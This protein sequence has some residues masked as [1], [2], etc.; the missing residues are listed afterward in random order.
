MLCWDTVFWDGPFPYSFCCWAA[1][2]RVRLAD[3][4]CGLSVVYAFVRVAGVCALLRALAGARSHGQCFPGHHHVSPG[5]GCRVGLVTRELAM[6]DSPDPSKTPE[7]CLCTMEWRGVHDFTW[8]YKTACPL[9]MSRHPRAWE[10]HL[11]YQALVGG[12]GYAGDPGG[13]NIIIDDG[14]VR[15]VFFRKDERT[16]LTRLLG[17][18]EEAR[19]SF[20]LGWTATLNWWG[21][22][23]MCVFYFYLLLLFLPSRDCVR[24]AWMTGVYVYA[25]DRPTLDVC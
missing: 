10:R 9:L 8:H 22:T 20:P 15:L 14:A 12:F 17:R 3:W 19:A 21:R 25:T 2:S 11:F 18:V 23:A 24:R 7:D 16:M 1:L 6:T 13:A 4:K 5:Q